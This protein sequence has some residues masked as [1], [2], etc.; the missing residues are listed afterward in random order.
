MSTLQCIL[1]I[2]APLI[3]GMVID[4]TCVAYRTLL[5]GGQGTCAVYELDDL[6]FGYHGLYIGIKI[7]T[8]LMFTVMMFVSRLKRYNSPQ[9]VDDRESG[10]VEMKMLKN[11][12]VKA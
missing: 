10:E 11:G 7:I 3:Y 12:T 8:V 2:P 9:E 6:R 1:V 4:S 5:G